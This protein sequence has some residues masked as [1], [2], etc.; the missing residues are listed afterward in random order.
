MSRQ[1]DDD[2]YYLDMCYEC[3][4]YGD[5]Y[6]F[7]EETGELESSCCTC[8]AFKHFQSNDRHQ[9]NDKGE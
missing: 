9:Q 3:T 5:D 7:D 2:Q 1:K 4:G 8:P 6:Y